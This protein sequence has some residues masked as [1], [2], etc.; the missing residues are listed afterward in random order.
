[1]NPL[2]SDSHPGRVIALRGLVVLASLA[3][4]L[5][6]VAAHAR[7]AAVDSDQFANR[8]TAALR[9]ESVNS[10]IAQKITD[11]LV[12]KNKAALI[13]ARPIIESVASA[14]VGGRAFTNLF[15]KAVRDLDR[16]L[17][18]HDE[19]TV[20]L[21]VT[22]VGTVL[23]AALEQ[24][25]PEL[26]DKLGS[27]KRVE[28]VTSDIGSVSAT[29]V[30]IAERVKLVALFLVLLS[31]ALA[32]GALVVRPTGGRRSWSLAWAWLW[33]AYCW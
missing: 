6:L 33:R 5:A 24:V 18:K 21:T 19:N 3:I 8:A 27:T 12:L 4:V 28:L 2:D 16:A 10:V 9:D 32:A 23:A 17:F 11:E 1:V 14:I 20:T 31:L 7:H 30:D 22:D 29:L 26:A 25:R 13:A 15:R